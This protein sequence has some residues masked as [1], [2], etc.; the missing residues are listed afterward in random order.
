MERGS[1]FRSP[2][3]DGERDVSDVRQGTRSQC[4]ADRLAAAADVAA[5]VGVDAHYLPGGKRKY[6]APATA[7]PAASDL[8]P[9]TVE[10]FI[11]CQHLGI[12][13]LRALGAE[14]A[15]RIAV[16]PFVAQIT[17]SVLDGYRLIAAHQRRHFEQARRVIEH[18]AFPSTWPA[19]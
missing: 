19:P 14:D 3:Q 1:V 10:R 4:R 9:L 5:D 16:S 6:R 18:P 12:A 15:R 13:R 2:A 8:D 11:A 17:Y 7:Q